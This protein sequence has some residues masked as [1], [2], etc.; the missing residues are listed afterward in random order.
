[1]TQ[2]ALSL[3][4]SDFD[5]SSLGGVVMSLPCRPV[6]TISVWWVRTMM[7][8]TVQVGSMTGTVPPGSFVGHS[9]A[10][11]RAV[12][13]LIFGWKGETTVSRKRIPCCPCK[14]KREYD[15]IFITSHWSC[16]RNQRM[17]PAHVLRLTVTWLKIRLSSLCNL[18]SWM[19]PIHLY[20]RLF[21]TSETGI[22]PTILW[23]L[24]LEILCSQMRKFRLF[25]FRTWYEMEIRETII[26]IFLSCFFLYLCF[27]I[28]WDNRLSALPS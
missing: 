14:Q 2:K 1:M 11:A 25:S 21:H 12:I 22:T 4:W 13:I 19:R 5:L 10:A 6:D 20:L 23:S 3:H 26:N 28:R 27:K 17:P 9:T 24:V 15:E 16:L 18:T 8:H 7:I